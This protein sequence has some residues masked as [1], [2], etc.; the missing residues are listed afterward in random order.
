MM[1]LLRSRT[2]R[3]P[4]QSGLEERSSRT[5]AAPG[6]ALPAAHLRVGG[7]RGVGVPELVGN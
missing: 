1:S 5:S 4:S 7:Q 6:R 2:D 3:E